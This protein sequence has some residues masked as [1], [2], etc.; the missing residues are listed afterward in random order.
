[1][2][3]DSSTVFSLGESAPE[4]LGPML[5]PQYNRHL[6]IQQ[7]LQNRATKLM[8]VPELPLYEARWREL[9]CLSVEYL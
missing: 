5:T 3:G 4:V 8:E 7:K 6:N 9:G 1:M 2:G